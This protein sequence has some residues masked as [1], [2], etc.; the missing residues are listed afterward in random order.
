MKYSELLEKEKRKIK[1]KVI[2]F[3]KFYLVLLI[4]VA[5]LSIIEH[6]L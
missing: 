5:L 1:V 6:A 3:A 2:W 4:A